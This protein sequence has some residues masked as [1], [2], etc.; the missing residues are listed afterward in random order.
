MTLYHPLHPDNMSEVITIP[1]DCIPANP[2]IAGIGIRVSV[3]LQNTLCVLV[4]IWTIIGRREGTGTPQ[5]GIRLIYA[6]V[7]G[8]ILTTGALFLSAFIQSRN[9]G[10]SAYHAIIVLNLGW[11]NYA[12]NLLYSNIAIMHRLLNTSVSDLQDPYNSL[13]LGFVGAVSDPY[14]N[15]GGDFSRFN[16]FS[17]LWMHA[18][19]GLYAGFGLWFWAT[20]D[21]FG[22][23]IQCKTGLPIPIRIL[24]HTYFSNSSA[25]RIAFLVIY[26]SFG[27]NAAVGLYRSGSTL[28]MGTISKKPA[29]S[30][31]SGEGR[32][33]FTLFPSL[34]GGPSSFGR[35]FYMY[36]VMIDIGFLVGIIVGTEWMVNEATSFVQP[37]ESQWTYGQTI[38]VFLLA[39]GVLGILHDLIEE[40]KK[41]RLV[42]RDTEE[43]Q[44]DTIKRD[45][46]LN[47]SHR[48]R[49][50]GSEVDTGNKMSTAKP[51]SEV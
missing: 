3:Y 41:K 2:D 28:I 43:Q 8:I 16:F 7:T 30:T 40:E 48:G 33:I 49:N 42:K 50:S 4:A 17:S 12:S 34:F 29:Q 1:P 18:S 20:V 6:Q 5:G 15:S 14:S 22:S 27:S 23:T 9:Y 21:T 37:G 13:R 47:G 35:V 31:P 36:V 38:S 51:S 45:G 26:T 32:S 25:T 24:G 10:L 19:M 44:L 46:G 39:P 11:V